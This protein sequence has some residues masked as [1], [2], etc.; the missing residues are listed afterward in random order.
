MDL[1]F[2]IAGAVATVATL[3]VITATNAVH[4]LLYFIV[5]LLSVAVIFYALGAPFAAVLEVIVYAG[6]IVV[7]FVFVVMML[8]VDDAAI[9]RERMWLTPRA[10]AGPALLCAV[11]LAVVVVGLLRD[12]SMGTAGSHELPAKMVGAA[13]FGRYVLAVELASFLLLSAMV[14]ATHLGRKKGAEKEERSSENSER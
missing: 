8:Q 13:L 3:M 5:S 9:A 4:A 11:L 12:T 14:T 7:L 6:A 10:W 2:Y 1:T